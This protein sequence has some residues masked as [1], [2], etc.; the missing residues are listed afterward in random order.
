M[1]GK[2][3]KITC[4]MCPRGCKVRV[5]HD[6]GEVKDVIGFA[7]PNGE[8][9][10]IEEIKSPSRVVMSVVECENGDIPTVSIK[11][12]KSVPKEKIRKVMEKLSE[13]KV[14]CPVEIG[15]T[16]LE[17]IAETDADII[18]TRPAGKNPKL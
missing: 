1:S 5:T 15:D 17:N 2:T 11:T 3:E 13:V 4:I 10:A 8:E 14:K 6:E 12:S 18:A 9:Y 16:I 7:C